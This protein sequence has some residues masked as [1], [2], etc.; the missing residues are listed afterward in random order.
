MQKDLTSIIL[1]NWNNLEEIKLCLRAIKQATQ[2]P[3]EVVIVDNGSTDGSSEYL[4]TLSGI[5]YVRP[6]P[7]MSF[8]AANNLGVKGAQGE[9]ICILNN[10][11]APIIGWLTALKNA[12][13]ENGRLGVV[14]PQIV[15][16]QGYIQFSGGVIKSLSEGTTDHL[17]DALP[18]HAL[19]RV[20][21]YITGA[22]MF[23]R[24]ELWD[25]LGGFDERFDPI[26][27]EDVDLCLRTKQLG[28]LCAVVPQSVIMHEVSKTLDR[29]PQRKQKA[30]EGNRKRFVEKWVGVK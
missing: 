7:P 19:P 10:D 30:I 3:H 28:Y 29:D 15:A 4:T 1:L 12:L 17:Y 20:C 13:K 2:E 25:K 23:L 6:P 8:A 26:F 22:C 24:R 21:D 9:Y 18:P 5:E 11:T 27:Y 16:R 14:G